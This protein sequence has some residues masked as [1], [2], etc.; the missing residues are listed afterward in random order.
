MRLAIPISAG[1]VGQMLMGV[2]DTIMVGHVSTLALAACAFANNVLVVAAVAGFGVLTAVSVRV[3]HAY[4]SGHAP[5]MAR[6]FHAGSGLAV[7]GGVAAA[8]LIH[9]L[10][11]LLHFLGQAPGVVE[12]ARGYLLII[13]WSLLPAWI[14][15]S[16]RNYLD[17]QSHPWPSFWIMLGGVL[18]NVLLNWIL[19]FGHLGMPA[20][21]LFG[22]GLATLL[23]RIITAAV[24]LGFIYAG[25]WRPCEPMRFGR[26]W[27]GEQWAMLRLG[28]PAGLQLSC[29]TT[30]LATAAML[31][32]LL[33][34]A[35]LAAHQIAMTC[36]STTYMF[37]LGIAMAATV[38]VAQA[39]GA[40][41]RHL[42]RPIA[43]GAWGT[44]IVVMAVFAALFLIASTPIASAFVRDPAVIGLA[45]PLLMIAG[46]FQLVDGVQVV[47]TGL[48]RGLR[49]TRG[50]ML[51]TMA[52]YWLVALPL[53][54]WL[55]FHG[56]MG[57]RGIWIGF[58]SGLAVAAALLVRRF[59]SRTA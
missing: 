26:A 28:V 4:G 10:Y 45:A 51:I 35:P 17:A 38:R 1:Y 16:A 49:D 9:A 2:A 24:L 6:A 33:G 55:A 25:R 59:F 47:G 18:L 48:L 32:G 7:A 29:E 44:G 8:L 14:T 37:P 3:S 53:G 20:L 40:G 12:E 46:I 56:G 30:A 58:A 54:A 21:G 19:I 31:I 36:A 39:T 11:P 43:A 42:L 34:A 27:W 23:S 13:G 5:A 41:D 50:P 52:A 57:A 15:A 22:A